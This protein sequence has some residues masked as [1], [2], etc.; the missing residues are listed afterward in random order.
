[1]HSYFRKVITERNDA[2]VEV[3]MLEPYSVYKIILR[4]SRGSLSTCTL[5]Q[6]EPLAFIVP[7]D[8]NLMIE[9]GL[10]VGKIYG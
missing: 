9:T 2:G 10:E 6:L 1:M 7:N 3:A 8:L 5:D 4:C